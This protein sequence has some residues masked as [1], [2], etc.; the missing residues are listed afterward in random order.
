MERLFINVFLV[1]AG[2]CVGSVARYLLTLGTQSLSMVLPFGTFFANT[3]GCFLI[4]FVSQLALGTGLVRPRTRLLLTT[5]FCGGF[6]TMS[7]FVYEAGHMVEAR[8]YL[9]AAA[10]FG[11]TLAGSFIAFFAGMIAARIISRGIQA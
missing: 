8:E 10:Y 2:G 1:G 4:G 3:A 5:G 6:T 11:A 9:R 7:S